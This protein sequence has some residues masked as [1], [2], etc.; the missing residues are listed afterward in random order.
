M[1]TYKQK[2]EG[3]DFA[4]EVAEEVAL[5]VVEKTLDE[6]SLSSLTLGS[7][8]LGNQDA[9]LVLYANVGGFSLDA[10]QSIFQSRQNAL[11]FSFGTDGVLVLKAYFGVLN[12]FLTET[13]LKIKKG[14]NMII[15]SPNG[16]EYKIEVSDS[17][18][19]SAV[20]V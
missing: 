20:A 2:K 14:K 12:Q 6:G 11:G 19:L 16:T 5:E 13:D 15:E 3:E 18:T 7:D 9:T 4:K 10:A 8:E 1:I 17:G